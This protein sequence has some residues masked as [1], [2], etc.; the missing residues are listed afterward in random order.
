MITEQSQVKGVIFDLD[1][2]LLARSPRHSDR[3][4]LA[5][6]GLDIGLSALQGLGI[7][8]GVITGASEVSAHRLLGDAGV[9]TFFTNEYVLGGDSI[10]DFS[11]SEVHTQKKPGIL[12]LLGAKKLDIT[13]TKESRLLKGKPSPDGVN[14]L[15]G[16]WELT[17]GQVVLVG[18][19]DI[20]RCCAEA[21]GVNYREIASITIQNTSLIDFLNNEVLLNG[22]F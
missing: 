19:D 22:D 7:R 20:D 21:A 8:L 4:I 3:M 14:Y 11:V 15:L 1:D 17:T 10:R 2:T 5:R 12:G 9:D 18:D 6:A 13:V 16:K